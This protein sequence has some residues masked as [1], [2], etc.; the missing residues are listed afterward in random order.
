M[1]VIS[2]FHSPPPTYSPFVFFAKLVFPSFSSLPSHSCR[3]RGALGET[4]RLTGVPSPAGI[5]AE[6]SV[7]G[8]TTSFDGGGRP[9]RPIGGGNKGPGIAPG[10]T[11]LFYLV[12]V[13][14]T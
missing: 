10:S 1:P 2:P 6:S 9:G 8:H 11:Y 14:A 4:Q 7:H 13:H 12:N 3:D 5:L